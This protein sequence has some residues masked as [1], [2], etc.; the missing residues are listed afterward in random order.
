M[1][2]LYLSPNIITP[3]TIPVVT[4]LHIIP[5][6]DP[7]IAVSHVPLLTAAP[8]SQPILVSEE[9]NLLQDRDRCLSIREARKIRNREASI[10]SRKKQKE[11]M[12]QLQSRNALLQQENQS[13]KNENQE[14]RHRIELLQEELTQCKCSDKRSLNLHSTSKRKAISLLA[15]VFLI[16]MNVGPY[17]IFKA[18]ETTDLPI[19]STERTGRSLLFVPD[20]D[21][22]D[23]RDTENVI[24]NTTTMNGTFSSNCGKF[25]NRTETQRVENELRGWVQRLEKQ[26]LRSK[27]E[28][29]PK[30]TIPRPFEKPISMARMK[31]FL[32]DSEEASPGKQVFQPSVRKNMD[33]LLDAIHRRDDTYYFVSLSPEDHMLFAAQANKTKVRPRFSFILP[34]VSATNE[35][36]T[37]YTMMQID[38]E[39]MNTKTVLVKNLLA[40]TSSTTMTPSLPSSHQTNSHVRKLSMKRR[41]LSTK[42]QS[43]ATHV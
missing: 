42:A 18:P 2:N 34:A 27:M 37:A 4:P 21:Y 16:G 7:V 40:A 8:V 3:V 17:G 22:S 24:L 20:Y 12:G 13:L 25:I 11:T 43:N 5:T 28:R 30:K 10:L 6:P 1:S 29:R 26:K 15:V 39:V 32:L 23:F 35:T 33:S 9:K 41:P 19:K 31:A 14:L 36:F 38:C